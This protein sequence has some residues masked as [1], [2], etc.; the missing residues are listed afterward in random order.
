MRIHSIGELVGVVPEGLV[1]VAVPA[2]E[3]GDDIVERPLHLLLVQRQDA[4][5]HR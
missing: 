2:L 1:E 4:L 5:Q 3:A